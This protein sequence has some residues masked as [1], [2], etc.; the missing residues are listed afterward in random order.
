MNVRLFNKK[1]KR[2]GAVLVG[3]DF[4]AIAVWSAAIIDQKEGTLLV[5]KVVGE[6]VPPPKGEYLVVF[7]EMLISFYTLKQ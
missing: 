5:S 2:T 6:A 1:K 4:G 7:L 3:H